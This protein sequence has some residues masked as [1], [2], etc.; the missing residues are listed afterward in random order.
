MP[1]PMPFVPAVTMKQR[2]A[3][4]NGSGAR[5]VILVSYLFAVAR[6]RVEQ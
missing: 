4:S 5:S 3:R 6:Y 2:P 1:L